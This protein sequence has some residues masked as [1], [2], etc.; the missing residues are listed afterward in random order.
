MAYRYFFIVLFII[1]ALL[2]KAQDFS[3]FEQQKK[4]YV[5]DISK[6]KILKG[7]DK[8]ELN[9]QLKKLDKNKKH[10][11]V[12]VLGDSVLLN[13]DYLDNL[14]QVFQKNSKNKSKSF[15]L[16]LVDKSLKSVVIK[17]VYDKK[18]NITGEDA[19][20]IAEKSLPLFFGDSGDFYQGSIRVSEL[21]I[22]QLV[23]KKYYYVNFTRI[24]VYGITLA[25]IITLIFVARAYE[26]KW[27]IE[28]LI[29]VVGTVALDLTLWFSNAVH[30][31]FSWLLL[32][33]DFVVLCIFTF[34]IIM[35]EGGSPTY[36]SIKALVQL[37]RP[38]LKQRFL[39]SEVDIMFDGYVHDGKVMAKANDEKGLEELLEKVKNTI[40][41]PEESFTPRE[42]ERLETLAEEIRLQANRFE[43]LHKDYILEKIEDEKFYFND[44]PA[45]DVSP[46]E[47]KRLEETLNK[48]QVY[49]NSENDIFNKYLYT[50]QQ[51][52]D[53][54]FWTNAQSFYYPKAKVADIKR[55]FEIAFK[56]P[57]LLDNQ[58][59]IE[60]LYLKI[61]NFY[62]NPEQFVKLR[63]DIVL[64][65]LE[66]NPKFKAILE[67]EYFNKEKQQALQKKFADD[68]AYFDRIAE[69]DLSILDEQRLNESLNFYKQVF[70]NPTQVIGYDYEW[71]KS[72][73][74]KFMAN[75]P[76]EEY[77]GKYTPESIHRTQQDFDFRYDKV[78]ELPDKLELLPYFY[79]NF[80]K[81]IKKNPHKFLYK[82][83]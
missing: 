60:E 18:E 19:S 13:Q 5:F 26:T 50:K 23:P 25:F 66:Q 72:E 37:N 12:I 59:D 69:Q 8:K 16:V 20:N 17:A 73:I 83:M 74:D 6:D 41:K 44:I 43:E 80:I 58:E 51:L 48:Y 36:E 76:W 47:I 82:L 62:Q 38:K 79:F 15:Y 28:A 39:P 56:V 21:L 57:D 30:P 77:H 7:N 2:V 31:G 71:L 11:I 35:S 1:N 70:Q 55:E 32:S 52:D 9:S 68:S 10:K 27:L 14:V 45:E 49:T 67:E 81:E 34:K 42:G 33:I 40:A 46:E 78:N 65:R 75:Q 4:T 61:R 29:V 54:Q 53:S 64:K 22:N 63:H 3:I 24:L